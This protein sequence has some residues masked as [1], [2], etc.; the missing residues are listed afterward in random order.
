MHVPDDVEDL[1]HQ[2]RRKTHG[3]LVQ[4]QHGGVAHQRAAHGQHLLFAA[5]H[6]AGQ[7]LAAFLQ[8]GEQLKDLFLVGGNG[9][10]G[11]GVGTHVQIFF[12]GHV[13]EHMASFGNMGKARFHDFMGA[14]ALDA[15]AL[16]DHIAG[17]GFQ[18]AGDG[19]QGGGLTGTIGTDQGDDLALIDL[20]GNA[21][22]GVDVAVVNVDVIDLQ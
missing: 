6:G 18:Q 5:G 3:R 20:E 11:L 1:L 10:V 16:V 4:H 17:L 19:L 15:L 14:H 21:L 12:H 9:G 22:D 8:A 13:Q 7:L 2:Q